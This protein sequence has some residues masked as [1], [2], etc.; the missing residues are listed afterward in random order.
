MEL[1]NQVGIPT[2]ILAKGSQGLYFL[3]S[4]SGCSLDV[5]PRLC[6]CVLFN[7]RQQFQVKSAAAHC[8]PA[9]PMARGFLLGFG[10]W[11][12]G[13]RGIYIDNL[14]PWDRVYWW[15]E[16]PLCN[17]HFSVNHGWVMKHHPMKTQICLPFYLVLCEQF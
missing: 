15:V 7:S 9:L 3:T 14:L 8:K 16:F 2:V 10:S 4:K 11:L 13:P 12:S 17:C 1:G 6:Q 5:C